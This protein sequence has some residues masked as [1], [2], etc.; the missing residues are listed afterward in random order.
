MT[1]D[2]YDFNPSAATWALM[3]TGIV[4]FVV[5][6]CVLLIYFIARSEALSTGRPHLSRQSEKTPVEAA[7]SGARTAPQPRSA[8]WSAATHRHA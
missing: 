5:A 4:V 2:Y 7:S 6:L 1:N 8:R 3:L